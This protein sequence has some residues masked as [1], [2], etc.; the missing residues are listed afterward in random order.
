IGVPSAGL[1]LILGVDR[2]LDMLRT[3]NNVT[4]DTM[5]A[6]VVAASENQLNFPTDGVSVATSDVQ[7]TIHEETV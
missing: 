1:A 5:V 6:S 4:G 7:S 3:T 2:P